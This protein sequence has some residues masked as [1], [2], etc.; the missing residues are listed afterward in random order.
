M[1]AKRDC[2]CHLDSPPIQVTQ[3]DILT[4]LD[5]HLH[6]YIHRLAPERYFR[7]RKVPCPVALVQ[8]LADLVVGFLL[9][10]AVLAEQMD[11]IVVEAH[12]LLFVKGEDIVLAVLP[13]VR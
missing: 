4:P 6:L 5:I 13:F 9:G 2:L 11:D 12:E 7:V 8:E 1:Q 3:N 10:E